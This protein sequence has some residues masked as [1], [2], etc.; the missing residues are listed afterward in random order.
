LS[1]GGSQPSSSVGTQPTRQS[2]INANRMPL[3]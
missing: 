1:G 2:A 3:I